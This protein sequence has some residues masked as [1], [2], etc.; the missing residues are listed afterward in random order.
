MTSL[1]IAAFALLTALSVATAIVLVATIR[2]VGVLH[3]RIRPAGAGTHE[4]P[5]A[6]SELPVPTFTPITPVAADAWPLAG[7]L[8]VLAYINP[9]CA[10]CDDLRHAVAGYLRAAPREA[11]SFIFATDAL[12]EVAQRYATD[13]EL[14]APLFHAAAL[15]TLWDLPGSPYV[16]AFAAASQSSVRLIQSGV[17]NSLEQLEIFMDAVHASA[18][19]EPAAVAESTHARP[20]V[21]APT[22]ASNAG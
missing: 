21:V 6:G 10:V 17:V 20:E 11:V 9:G 15:S 19:E 8:T 13:T 2:Q 5:A 22:I 3:Q 16:L 18:A 14:A 1:W 7:D 4:G 12:M